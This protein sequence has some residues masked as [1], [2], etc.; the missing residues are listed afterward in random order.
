MGVIVGLSSLS[1]D[2]DELEID[3]ITNIGHHDERGNDT[4]TLTGSHART[5]LA[6]PNVMSGRQ[7]SADGVLSHSQEKS[8][9]VYQRLSARDPVD[10]II[11]AKVLVE[12]CNIIER[13]EGVVLVLAGCRRNTR[14]K[15][16]R[17]ERVASTEAVRANTALVVH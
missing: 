7:Q 11:I 10:A 12:T 17:E 6:I 1:V 8:I 15:R 5:N 2:T 16:I 9:I 4:S 13:L 14:V 3:F